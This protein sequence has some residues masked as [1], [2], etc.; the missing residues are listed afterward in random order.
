MD[1]RVYDPVTAQ[2]LSPDPYIQE[3]DNLQN[4]NRYAYCLFNPINLIDPTG[5]QFGTPWFSISASGVS[6]LFGQAF[7]YRNLPTLVI[8]P[9]VIPQPKANFMNNLGAVTPG[10]FM[11]KEFDCLEMK[12]EIQ[13]KGYERIKDITFPEW[14]AHLDKRLKNAKVGSRQQCTNAKLYNLV[15]I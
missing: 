8:T 1:G 3:P 11:E 13:T 9:Y 12:E 15:V 10:A 6:Y 2:F 14:R 7:Y 5:E 4:Y